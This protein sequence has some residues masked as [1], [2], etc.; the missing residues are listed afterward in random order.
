MKLLL[1]YDQSE[2]ILSQG[3][4]GE[5]VTNQQREH[6]S[7]LT[8]GSMQ[9]SNSVKR[10]KEVTVKH[11]L[12]NFQKLGRLSDRQTEGSSNGG[13]DDGYDEDSLEERSISRGSSS[14]E[15]SNWVVSVDKI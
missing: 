8:I 2:E 13:S 12:E 15:F 11:I 9:E 6:Q 10:L 3:D 5:E 4:Y 14:D 7:E 1:S